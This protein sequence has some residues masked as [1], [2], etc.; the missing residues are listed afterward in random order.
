[1]LALQ[2]RSAPMSTSR[3]AAE[4]PF[5]RTAAPARSDRLPMSQ[6][7]GYGVGAAVDMWGHWLYPTL[8]FPVFN[9]FLGV[10]PWLISVALMLV[11]LLDAAYDPLFGWLSDNTRGPF[12]RRRPYI[13]AGAIVAGVG[14]PLLFLVNPGWGG[15]TY[16]FQ[17]F[18]WSEDVYVSRYFW[19]M[20]GSAALFAPAMACFNTPYQSLGAELTPDYHERTSVMMVRNLIQQVVCVGLYFAPQ[21][22]TLAW[23]NDAQTGKPNILLG[24]QVY[25]AA[26]GGL[27]I[28]AGIGVFSCVHERYYDNVVAR[29]Q[30]R[31]SFKETLCLALRCQPFRIQL[32]MTLAFAIGTSMT[33]TLGFYDTVYY[34]CQGDVALGA[35]WNAWM[36]LSG[37]ALGFPGILLCGWL[38]RRWGKPKTMRIVLATAGLAFAATWW[39]YNPDLPWLLLLTT[40]SF[41]FSAAA[42]WT[43][44]GSMNADVMDA[45]E[46]AT[47]KRREGAFAACSSWI[48]KLGLAAGTGA[49]GLLLSATGFDASLEGG[50]SEQTLLMIRLF[51]AGVPI[52]GF[53]VAAFALRRFPLS[54]GRMREIRLELERRRG[55]I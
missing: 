19:F 55:V 43:L 17:L 20:L 7:I 24:A 39:L 3:I 9:I 35:R 44:A 6:K 41:S 27:M 52:V 50:Q 12:G 51:V 18:G 53:V 21:F 38:A 25:T 48:M 40:A 45:D 8:A 26:L 11:R 22:V 10:P 14:L 54:P 2:V 23:F 42:F 46:L 13:L 16:H 15:S 30:P 32:I 5:A 33:G 28:L 1:M 31:S 4:A 29:R 47:G 34:V 49:C 36:G 37:M